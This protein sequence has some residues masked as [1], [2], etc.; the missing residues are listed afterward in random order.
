[1]KWEW[2]ESKDNFLS[3]FEWNV[4]NWGCSLALFFGGLWAGPPANAPQRRETSENKQT[5]LLFHSQENNQANELSEFGWVVCEESG[6]WAQRAIPNKQ[7]HSPSLFISLTFFVFI[8]TNSS[9]LSLLF[10]S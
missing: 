5:Q 9:L 6:L 4:F 2:N 8:N 1:M 10:N 7:T 3:L